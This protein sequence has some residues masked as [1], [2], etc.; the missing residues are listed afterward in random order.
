MVKFSETLEDDG[1]ENL[2]ELDTMLD[3]TTLEG[4][5]KLFE[6]LNNLDEKWS[7]YKQ[8][9]EIFLRTKN[10]IGYTNMDYMKALMCYTAIKD[11]LRPSDIRGL[12][13]LFKL[14]QNV[15]V[16][17]ICKGLH[18]IGLKYPD[19]G[20]F[21]MSLLNYIEENTPFDE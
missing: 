13:K 14:N 8:M 1:K 3:E 6:F 19:K 2:S 17:S 11:L 21:I 5:E 18:L 15:N 7:K 16:I 10:I 9:I 20:I 4:E 12:D